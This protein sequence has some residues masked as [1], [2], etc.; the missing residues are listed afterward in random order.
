M[1]SLLEQIETEAV[2][3]IPKRSSILVAVSGGLDSMALL[4]ALNQV[5][6]KNR[7]QLTVA[8]FNHKLRGHASNAD[9]RL[10]ESFAKKHKINHI[11]NAWRKDSKAAKE[12]GLEMAAREARYDFLQKEAQIRQCKYIAT[13][14]H[15]DDQ[16]E[17]FLWRLMRGAGGKGLGGMRPVSDFYR[18]AEIILARPLLK[19]SKLDLYQLAEDHAVPF[20]EDESND[21]LKHLRNK[22]R[23]RL[24]PYLKRHFHP[25][26]EFPILQSQS[27]IFD[28]ADFASQTAR[29]WLDLN[30]RVPFKRLHVAVQRWVIWHQ[31]IEL[32]VDPQYHQVENLRQT[33]NRPFSINLHHALVRDPTGC[34]NLREISKLA[35]RPE[36]LNLSLTRRWTE[37][38]FSNTIIR[39]RIIPSKPT[40]NDGELLDADR[41]GNNILLR[42]W[43][44]GDRFQPIGMKGSV[45]LQD[46]F[47]NAKIPAAEK[48]QRIL[49]CT[50]M[51]QLF[52]IQKFRISDFAK[53][54]PKT[55]R[56][57]QWHWQRS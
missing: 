13:A 24:L 4:F 54:T 31:L 57:L 49:A 27:L 40:K 38:I 15:A 39:C 26:I 51:G 16:V 48:R 32:G 18:N 23:R 6:A 46:L 1:A 37:V 7:W 53:I 29:I 28:E 2:A 11:S 19:F 21:D 52:W 45:K 17:T 47:T 35:F 34:V 10:V 14:H 33:N 41:V 30:E 36:Q 9:Q 20:R 42:H 44:P 8:H 12:H 55:K 50:E 3:L 25:E 22:I 56:F 5:V 43:R